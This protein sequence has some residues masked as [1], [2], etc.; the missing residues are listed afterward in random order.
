MTKLGLIQCQRFLRFLGLILNVFKGHRI[1]TLDAGSLC[2]CNGPHQ[3]CSTLFNLSTFSSIC[4]ILHFCLKTKQENL[5]G[6]DNKK[7]LFVSVV[8][9]WFLR[10][11]IQFPSRYL[12]PDLVP[13]QVQF[14][15]QFLVQNLVPN[16]VPQDL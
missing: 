2:R 8:V 4:S 1:H 11:Q 15:G 7:T 12:V 13:V 14:L 16:L 3:K 9:T 5:T 10:N 6:L